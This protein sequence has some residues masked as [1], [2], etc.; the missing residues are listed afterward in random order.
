MQKPKTFRSILFPS[1]TVFF[2]SACIMTLELVA[3]RLIARHLGSSLYTWTSVIGIVLAGITIGN[4]IGGRIADR[5]PARKAIAVLL[6]I[7]SVTCVATVILNNLVGEW[8]LLWHFRWPLRVF[9]HVFLV[10]IVPSTLLGTISPVVAKM[11]LDQGLPTGRTVG[12]IYAWGAAG[13]IAGT[14]LTGYYLIA[15]MGTIAIIWTVAA[16]LLAMA[17]L[18]W[19]RFWALYIWAII[20]IALMTM[21]VAPLDWAEDTAATLT[22][23][24]TPDPDVIYQDETQ[25]C[26]V[27]VKRISEKPDRRYFMQDKLVH[28]QIIMDDINDLQYFHTIVFASIT[29]GLA[30]NKQSF[31]AMHIGGGGYVFPQYIEK[32]WPACR[33]DVAEID[34]GVTKAATNAFGLKP[35]TN[36]NTV[37]MDARNY[38]D[39]LVA[40]RRNGKPTP[41][42]DFIYED[43]FSD[44]SVPHQLVTKE[45]HD[46]ICQIM[47]DDGLYMIN[48]IDIY[49][50]SLFLGAYINTLEKTFPHVYVVTEYKRF[51]SRNTF[52]IIAA[53]RQIK[54]DE[55]MKEEPARAKDLWI[56][57]ASD[58]ETLKKKAHKIT[59][60]DDFAPVENMLAPVVRKSG[61]DAL[62][63]KYQDLAQQLKHSG[64]FEQSIA[65]YRELIR[66]NP[67]MSITAYAE[68][69]NIRIQQG[70][71]EE[72][73]MAF[74]NA[75]SYNQNAQIKTN[76]ADV[77]LVLALTL[78][79]MGQAA[80]AKPHFQIA[81]EALKT[82]LT[83]DPRSHETLTKLGV[84]LAELGQLA[85]ATDHLQ[86]A[87]NINP[88]DFQ[89]Q[90]TLAR[91]LV[92]QKRY[93]EAITVL[94]HAITAATG[95]HA[96]NELQTYLQLVK[97][98]AKQ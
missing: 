20:F 42:Y 30:R 83:Q 41:L 31:A 79:S 2:S 85:E 26:Y 17:I 71:L 4:Y 39:D 90:L 22:L 47:T 5:F 44:Y 64:K 66:L 60:T 92:A 94:D 9:T 23:R 51:S 34:S 46:K 78:K 67:S 77:H 84:A 29:R 70:R 32:N 15:T 65:I 93:E 52:V 38:V 58:M 40:R 43:A 59:L 11:A 72:A 63:A 28:S 50:S 48:M 7:S 76:M 82:S 95:R 19:A 80:K 87:V 96:L 69:A 86:K 61:V 36:I 45:F 68:I 75:I 18:Y 35:D 81:A 62:A 57:G 37:T 53:K 98:K 25:Y 8:M 33:N 54:I 6:G 14:F 16:A 10:F 49:D 74:Q 3:S 21:A 91:T 1:A 13:S 73:A 97:S 55:L 88:S 56:L 89:C 24:Q 27:A 12:D